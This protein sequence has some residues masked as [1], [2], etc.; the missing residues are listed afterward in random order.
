[1]ECEM[2][3]LLAIG[4]I[5]LFFG[6]SIS[7][8]GYNVEMQSTIVTS[9][10]NTLYVG[11]SGPNNY[12]KIQDAINDSSNGD[13]VFVYD[14]SSPY[15]ENLIVNKSITLLGEEKNNTVIDGNGLGVVV[16][17]SANHV[18]IRCF[19][20]ING[21]VGIYYWGENNSVIEE[22]VI[23]GSPY[24]IELVGGSNNE[25]RNNIVNGGKGIYLSS[26]YESTVYGNIV[27]NCGHGIY[28]DH[29]SQNYIVNN[30]I[31]NNKGNIILINPCFYNQIY[32]NLISKA[33]LWHGI[34]IH[35]D[36]SKNTSYHNNF[37]DNSGGNAYDEGKNTWYKDYL[38]GG[39]FWDDYTGTDID[40]DG[41]GEHSYCIQNGS[42]RDFY[43]LMYPWYPT[44]PDTVYV[45][46]DFNVSTPDF[47]YDRFNTIKYGINEVP[48]GGLVYV[49]NGTYYE[50]IKINKKFNL[51]GEDKNSTIIDGSYKKENLV[52]I[53]KSDTTITGFTL[54]NC[55]GFGISWFFNCRNTKIYGNI[56]KNNDFGIHVINSINNHIYRNNIINNRVGINIADSNN[57]I[58]R[59]NIINN[60]L[61]INFVAYFGMYGTC[62]KN[63]IYKNNIMRN[64][65]GISLGR[66]SKQNSFYRNNIFLNNRNCFYSGS[67]N[68][69]DS[70]YWDDWI[71]IK[72]K[73][74]IFQIFPKVIRGWI[75]PRGFDWDPASEPYDIEV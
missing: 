11:G 2:K 69:W 34:K 75:F 31:E 16:R 74:P 23:K 36:C 24:G 26:T 52:L 27:T 17:I 3:R 71:G 32:E 48:G 45:D 1:M 29:S 47:G 7:S 58:Y 35:N 63:S 62:S 60:S 43:P 59:N 53:K 64:D 4:V 19:T 20:I 6:M 56:I 68:Y 70:N 61:G 72:L 14:D 54:Q 37:Y 51:I 55:S 21:S 8:T 13:I 57:E 33:T 9:R 5:L 28:I 50:N 42:N 49:Y 38:S 41:I 30:V 40:G 46:D 44:H 66:D 10:G 18:N 73:L 39:N 67:N 15:Y 22:N 12:T 65:E 25:I